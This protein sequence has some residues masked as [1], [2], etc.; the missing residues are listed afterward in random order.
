LLSHSLDPNS[1][2]F[3][4]IC[5][6]D[7]DQ[8]LA[9]KILRKISWGEMSSA[10]PKLPSSRA[11][12]T[13]T[14]G[15]LTPKQA[16]EIIIKEGHFPAL[17]RELRKAGIVTNIGAQQM[18]LRSLLQAR[19]DEI[20]AERIACQFPIARERSCEVSSALMDSDIVQ[21]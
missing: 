3:G 17:Q 18:L 20:D 2:S 19:M 15:D 13:L 21:G 6:I 11:I 5:S 16:A 1:V 14:F 10:T 4:E 7:K 9:S 8:G 12:K